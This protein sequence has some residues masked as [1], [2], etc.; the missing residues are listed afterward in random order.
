[1]RW[2]GV[3]TARNRKRKTREQNAGHEDT[4]VAAEQLET[5]AVD[6]SLDSNEQKARDSGTKRRRQREVDDDTDFEKDMQQKEVQQRLAEEAL[7]VDAQKRRAEAARHWEKARNEFK[8]SKRSVDCNGR[9]R[10][11]LSL[12]LCCKQCL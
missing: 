1:M 2:T 7:L 11:S 8:L 12:N 6:W 5:D 3:W 4:T 10:I 9:E